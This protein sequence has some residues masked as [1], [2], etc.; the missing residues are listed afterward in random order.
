M[1]IG[2][3]GCFADIPVTDDSTYKNGILCFAE[4]K[5]ESPVTKL[6]IVEIGISIFITI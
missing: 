6:Q 3:A 2:Y 5:P 4:K 1:T